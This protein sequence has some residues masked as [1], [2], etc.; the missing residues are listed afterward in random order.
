MSADSAT[1]GAPRAA[2]LRSGFCG[3]VREAG[4]DAEA[5]LPWRRNVAPRPDLVADASCTEDV[6]R[7]V[8]FCRE[9]G[10]D[11]G[12]QCG[13]HGAVRGQS[14][15]LLLRTG[16]VA[17]VS[18]DPESRTA[19][20]GGGARWRAVV[21][22]AARYGLAPV[23]GTSPEVGVAGY[24]LGGGLGWL[25]RRHGFAA[26]NLLGAEVVTAD[27]RV[28]RV[29]PDREA[30]L[31]WAL[32]GGGGNFGVATEL[33]M[34]LHPVKSVRGGVL[35]YP[36][37]RAHAILDAYRA[38][39][40][41]EPEDVVT[42]AVLLRLPD[43]AD[44][45]EPLRGRS[46]VALRVCVLSDD[47]RCRRH[48]DRLCA[49]AGT[50][51]LGGL[52]PMRFD[53]L[54]ALSDPQPE[55]QVSEEHTDL[56]RVLADEVIEELT[57][58]CFSPASPVSVVEV[59]N[60]SGAPARLAADTSPAGHRDAP[61]SVI[62]IAPRLTPEAHP[63]ARTE[64]ARL[65]GRLAPHAAGSVFL[66]FLSAPDRVAAAYTPGNLRRLVELKRRFDPANLFRFNHNIR[67]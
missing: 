44:L 40:A 34:R 32:R 21:A 39:A 36:G 62:A 41:D 49:A 11:L 13:G 8:A 27:A 15:G 19:R 7:A 38:S 4:R 54:T 22:A 31:F 16:G 37:E 47:R 14:G 61:F 46:V 51:L 23:S 58:T 33:E 28:L 3:A 45:P 26:D 48:V 52:R 50:P 30:E 24:C 6:R 57:A 5:W 25:T 53:E 67:P 1:A 9:H 56:F 17:R 65:A 64:T 18:V 29:G 43:S 63:A 20:V 55:A 10:H 35:F 66:N 42:A 12:V 59:R 60:W 2:G